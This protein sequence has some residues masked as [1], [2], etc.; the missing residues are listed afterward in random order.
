MLEMKGVDYSYK[1]KNHGE[2]TVFQNKSLTFEKGNVYALYG[3]SGSGKTTCLMLLGGLEK[4]D[5][6]EIILDNRNIAEIGYQKLRQRYVSYVFQDYQLFPYMTALENVMVARK[7]AHKEENKK[8]QQKKCVDL[9]VSL[10]L[11]QSQMS[12]RVTKLS[13][14][15]QQRVAIARALATEADYILADEPTGNLDKENTV[16]I[17]ELLKNIAYD[18]GKCV[19][20]VTHSEYVKNRCDVTYRISK[21]I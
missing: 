7:I 15:Q 19:V 5:K 8:E 2:V 4:P 6:G 17:I 12:R 3:P 16:S 13:G 21:E 9:L 14:G 20:I 1:G 11:E 10:G 18:K